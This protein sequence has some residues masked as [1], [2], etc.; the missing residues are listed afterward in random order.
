M[1]ILELAEQ[2]IATTRPSEAKKQGVND[3][4]DVMVRIRDYQILQQATSKKFKK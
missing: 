3:I 4:F 1:S 2:Y